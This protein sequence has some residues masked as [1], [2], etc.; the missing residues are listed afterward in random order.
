MQRGHVGRFCLQVILIGSPKQLYDDKSTVK[1]IKAAR[2]KYKGQVVFVTANTAE[3]ITDNILKFFG[4]SS[5]APA[6][7]VS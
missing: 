4:A 7:Q 6:V 5:D 1:A 2:D 3:S